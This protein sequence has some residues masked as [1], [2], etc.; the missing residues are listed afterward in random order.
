[1]KH[2][3]SPTT[4]RNRRWEQ[5]TIVHLSKALVQRVIDFNT[6]V[7]GKVQ[8]QYLPLHLQAP[9]G[10]AV[11]IVVAPDKGV[12]YTKGGDK[13]VVPLKVL[14]P[15]LRRR[16]RLSGRELT[17]DRAKTRLPGHLGWLEAHI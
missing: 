7:D 6:V 12:T 2:G 8:V 11:K 14:R 15:G 9:P 16:Y 10:A 13:R 3:I 17:A 5:D 4:P 1:M